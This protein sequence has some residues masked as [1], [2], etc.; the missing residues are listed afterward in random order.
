MQITSYLIPSQTWTGITPKKSGG[1]CPAASLEGCISSLLYAGAAGE[2]RT[3]SSLRMGT[4]CRLF[5]SLSMHRPG[6]Y[7]AQHQ[8]LKNAKAERYTQ[9]H[10]HPR[11]H[12]VAPR[13]ALFGVALG[14]QPRCVH[15]LWRPPLHMLPRGPFSMLQPPA[16]IRRTQLHLE[17]YPQEGS[18]ET[19][20]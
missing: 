16:S 9:K 13:G 19:R 7:A 10:K 2:L 12:Q 5:N 3:S 20:Q 11:A 14:R 8:G 6:H 15:D 1:R 17:R 4:A 18:E